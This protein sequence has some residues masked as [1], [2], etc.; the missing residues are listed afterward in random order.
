[1]KFLGRRFVKAPKYLT[2]RRL[3]AVSNWSFTAGTY[4]ASAIVL[5]LFV[6]DWRVT[7][8]FIPIYG[9]KFAEMDKAEEERLN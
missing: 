5:L 2:P 6:T 9:R 4:A 3:E 1:M 7:N 8:R